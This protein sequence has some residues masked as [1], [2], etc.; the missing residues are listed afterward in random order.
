LSRIYAAEQ[1]KAT[2]DSI[3]ALLAALKDQ[4]PLARAAAARALGAARNLD[5]VDPLIAILGDSDEQVEENAIRALGA[6]GDKRAV[7]PLISRGGHLLA[8]SRISRQ[9]LSP[10]LSR[11]YLISTSLGQIKDAKENKETVAFLKE[12]RTLPGGTIGSNV[13]TETALA[14][15][16]AD[17]F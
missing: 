2:K 11:L 7:A 5:A 8:R 13:E 16:G 4:S 17:S 14:R 10:E 1:G 12:V 15:M 3:S 9:P 6:L